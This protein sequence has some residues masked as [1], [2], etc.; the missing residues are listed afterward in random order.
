L[1]RVTHQTAYAYD[2]EVSV[3]HHVVQ[4]RPRELPWQRCLS[5][6]LCVRPDPGVEASR[7]DYFGNHSVLVTLETAHR[8]FEVIAGS[9]VEVLPRPSLAAVETP[10]WESV[11]AAC[12]APG[13]GDAAAAGEFRFESP[14]VPQ[15]PEI[16]AWA[17]ESFA[18]GR[19]WLAA[20]ADLNARI[21]RDFVFDG[22][23]TTV[24]TP[25]AEVFAKRRGVCQDFA[26]VMLA[27]ARAMG[28]PARYVSG[29]LETLPPPGNARLV[30]ADAS[31][32]WIAAWC[33]GLGWVDFDP[34]NDLL[35]SDRHVTVA[36]GRDFG[37]VSPVRGVLL[38]S[39]DHRIRVSV[40]VEAV[41]AGA[42]DDGGRSQSQSQ[43]QSFSTPA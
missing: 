28:L 16:G 20:M 3:S 24:T 29:Y 13:W 12:G 18:P 14:W 43:S 38:G 10:A 27:A 39:G 21:H 41:D 42:S 8:E 30:G 31:H 33:P 1:Y 23:A 5:H 32:A 7:T 19:G 26:H 6:Q 25:L 17:A 36:W 15:R 40:D 34:T 22:T 4:L 9:L 35:P 2:R 11:A 37:D